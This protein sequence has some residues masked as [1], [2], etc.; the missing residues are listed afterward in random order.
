MVFHGHHG[1]TP[2]ERETGQ[3]FHVDLDMELDLRL[4]GLS[5]DLAD[6]VD[7]SAVYQVVKGVVEGPSHNLLE[8]VAEELA[9]RVLDTF[10]LAAV[11]VR[12][13]KPNAPIPGA[14]LVVAGVEVHRR[15][16]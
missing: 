15:P 7:Y 8:S 9:Q 13:T 3:P 5:D 2:H 16:A 12:L 1:V 4:P 11:T 10:P 6:T 14:D